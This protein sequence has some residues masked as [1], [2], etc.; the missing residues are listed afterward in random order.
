[1]YGAWLSSVAALKHDNY[2]SNSRFHS[3]IVCYIVNDD[4][5]NKIEGKTERMTL[6]LDNEGL[7]CGSAE[8][9]D[10]IA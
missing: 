2:L 9:A 7:R 10:G 1:M 8:I 6:T 4:N 5:D 3:F